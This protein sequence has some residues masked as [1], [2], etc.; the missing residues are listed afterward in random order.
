MSRHLEIP[1][2]AIELE[3][4]VMLGSSIREKTDSL[5]WY[6][7]D[8]ALEVTKRYDT[9]ALKE[10][11]RLL[12][13][14]YATIRRYRLVSESYTPQERELYQKLTWSHFRYAA[15][16]ENKLDW[17]R[18]ADDQGWSCDKLV[19]MMKPT[20]IDDGKVVPP[21]PDLAFDS[22][23]RLWYIQ[24]KLEDARALGKVQ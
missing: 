16:M 23:S 10:F 19:A 6:L 8:L 3:D 22:V 21:R 12:G 13:I 18:R 7:G 2:E 15:A 24:D 4:L 20:A 5:N 14:K 17:L 9:K 11:S 1:S